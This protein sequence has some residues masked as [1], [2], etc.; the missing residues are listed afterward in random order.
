MFHGRALKSVITYTI[1]QQM[2]I[3]KYIQ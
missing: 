1:N 2:H 3:Y